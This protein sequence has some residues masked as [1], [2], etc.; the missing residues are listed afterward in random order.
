M[1]TKAALLLEMGRP[2]P[3]AKSAPIVIEELE[4][5]GPGPGEVLVE[6]A[7][8]GLC[9][10][11]L[12]VINGS[13]PRPMPMVLGHEAAGV[14]RELGS[15]VV[16]LKP[17]DHVVFSYVP[18]CRR[19]LECVAGRPAMCRVGAVANGAGT[20][21]SGAR[22]FK[23]RGEPVY[24]HLGVCGFS[25]FTV[26]SQESLVKIDPALPLDRAALFGCAIATGVGAVVNTARVEPA[27]SVAVFGLGGVG[28]AAIMG[29]K[30]CGARPIV[31]VDVL[32]SK[33]ELARKLG[34]THTVEASGGDVVERVRELT[35]GGAAYVFD[36]TGVAKVLEQAFAATARG[37]T[38]VV[39]G[40]PHPDHRA[41][42]S[43][44]AMVAEERVLKGCYMGSVIPWR[45]VPRFIE[46]YRAGLLPMD[47][48]ITGTVSLEELN[49]G[50]DRLDRGEAVRQVLRIHERAA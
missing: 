32:A 33:F 19:C 17:G 18:A 47:A 5:D 50:F 46:L 27:S 22:R 44:L 13:R 31:A 30:V 49:H 45:D 2:K 37:G 42:L 43:P 14:V 12:S 21:L 16:G 24:H 20:L 1:K 41:S 26:C 15:G 6:M 3:Y 39:I 36:A 48:L 28:L 9:H 10:S 40:L 34:A 11:D 25:E 35:D 8:A 38:T 23:R 29:A 4:L 7:A